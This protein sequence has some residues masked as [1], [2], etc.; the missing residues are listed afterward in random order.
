MI[1]EYSYSEVAVMIVLNN[2]LRVMF[3]TIIDMKTIAQKYGVTV[4]ALDS[5]LDN[6]HKMKLQQGFTL[7]ELMIV[8]AIIEI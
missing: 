7:I 3:K 8:I 1:S 5:A 2:T 4:A 6:S